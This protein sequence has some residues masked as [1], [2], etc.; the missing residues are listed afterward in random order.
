MANRTRYLLRRL[1]FTFIAIYVI[2]TILFF[3]FR[4]L[5]GDPTTAM[6]PP[7][8]S[9]AA[10]QELRRQ[11]GLNEPLYV[12]YFL[13]LK[14]LV[15]GNLGTSFTFGKPVTAVVI[16]RTINTLA[17][18][19]P[20]V[21]LSFTIGP[22][23]GSILAWYRGTRIDTYGIGLVLILRGAPVFWTG[24]VAI[25][26]FSFQLGWLPTGGMHSPEF[27][28]ESVVARLVSTDFLWH[29]LLPLS[30]VTLY[31]VSAPTFVMRNTMID[32]LNEDFIELLRA[33]G[34]SEFRI[35]YLHA[36]R[37]SM[38]PIVHYFALAMG[39]IFGGS[40]VIETVFSWPGVGR[41]MFRALTERDYPLIQGAFLMVAVM[42]IIM[43]FIADAVSV[44]IDPRAGEG[45]EG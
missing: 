19:I 32:V 33:E 43:N 23:I 3:M 39:A 44:Y 27:V 14:N 22:L 29:L 38:L 37:N 1:G 17:L 45:G 24:I 35:I 9:D 10:K 31:F 20:A 28:S 16:D 2:A 30:V 26:F 4:L 6:L 34:L 8:A 15:F 25:M 11:F 41:T 36:A 7:G 40:V 18:L 12:Q 5:P 42:V 13:Y 21:V